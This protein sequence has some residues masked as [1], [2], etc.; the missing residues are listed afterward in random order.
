M[1]N[2]D[3][4]EV[5]ISEAKTIYKTDDYIEDDLILF[6][7]VSDI[8]IPSEPRRMNCLLIAL[9]TNGKAQYTVDTTERN[10]TSGDIIIISEG[11]VT[12]NFMLSRDCNGI[13]IML[14]YNFFHEIIAGSHEQSALFLFS[15]SHPVF[16][17][18]TEEEAN[19]FNYVKLIKKKVEEK[20]HHFRKETVKLL[21][22]AMISDV[23]NII[24]KIQNDNN[25]K[26]T[27][28]ESIFNN[29]I[30]LVEQNYKKVRRVSW[31]GHQLCITPK[32]LSETVKAVSHRTPN[33]WIDNYVSLEIRVQLKN[34]TKS[35]KEI[36]EELH[37]PNQSFMGKYFKEQVGMSP[38]EYRKK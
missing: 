22:A 11:Q 26:Q 21:I 12:N 20:E 34:S 24:Y 30:Q 10:V 5:T 27:R 36:A 37:F 19:L 3:M 16:S 1:I 38:S 13:A 32:Y 25:T 14:S 23:S 2:T 18:N 9:C 33:E 15:K 28:A 6:D 4:K 8:P 29:F 7:S 35:I 31:Y 17:L